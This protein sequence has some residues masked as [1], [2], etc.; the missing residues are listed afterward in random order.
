MV[1]VSSYFNDQGL[2]SLKASFGEAE[3]QPEKRQRLMSSDTAG[4]K[5]FK[6]KMSSVI[7]EKYSMTVIDTLATLSPINNIMK[8][9]DDFLVSSGHF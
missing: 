7:P 4:S 6:K 1:F 8:L 3:E 2:F 5:D 9:G